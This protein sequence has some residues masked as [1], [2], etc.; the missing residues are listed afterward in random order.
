MLDPED[1]SEPATDEQ[2]AEP[3]RHAAAARLI[4]SHRG[5]VSQ[6]EQWLVS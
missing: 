3:F 2:P 1:L 4:D 6:E 5:S